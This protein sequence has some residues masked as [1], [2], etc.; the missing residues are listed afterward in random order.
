M[1]DRKFE[2]IEDLY[3]NYRWKSEAKF[4]PLAKK[5][6]FTASEARE[7]IRSKVD[8]DVIPK[9]PK[10]MHIYS[11]TGNEYQMDTFVN[12]KHKGGTNYLMIIN[13]NTRKA[14][15]YE[16][17]G[18]GSEA[19]LKALTEFI[20]DLENENREVIKITSD[21]DSAYLNDKVLSFM[22]NHGIHYRTTEDN[23]HNILGIINRFMRTVRDYFE[24]D[25]RI[26]PKMMKGFIQTYN[27]SPHRGLDG[28][29]PNE[30]TTD[31]ED[32]Y[33]KNISQVN[34]YKFNIGDHV[35][36][37]NVRAPLSKHRRKTTKEAYIIDSRE[38]NQFIIKSKD[39]S[40][41]K[42]PGYMLVKTKS[43]NIAETLKEGKRGIIET[44]DSYD[45][46]NDKY[47]VTYQGGVRDKIKSK[48]LREGNPTLL[49]SMEREFWVNKKDIPQNIRKWV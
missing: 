37:V 7:L 46:K 8:H 36:V 45:E 15:A 16:M 34:P 43:N 41:D 22:K 19:V 10:F 5:Y 17:N 6:G 32:A 24:D 47:H 28:K 1:S 42:Y 23:N 9:K 31:D 26:T 49:S 21:Q 27:N 29:I 44:I 4:V 40:V 48:N 30:M 20:N 39:E 2:T 3:D 33:I 25:R 13:I 18:K 35:K 11:K 38:G 14:Y 12:D